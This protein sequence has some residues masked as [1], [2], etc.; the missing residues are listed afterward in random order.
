[1]A[2]WLWL[3]PATVSVGLGLND[4][5]PGASSHG[6]NCASRRRIA[7]MNSHLLGILSSGDTFAASRQSGFYGWRLRSRWCYGEMR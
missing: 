6:T 4:P 2:R 3:V 7:T 5:A 1:V